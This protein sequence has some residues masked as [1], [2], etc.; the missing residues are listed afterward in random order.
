MINPD[1]LNAFLRMDGTATFTSGAV[2]L[3]LRGTALRASRSSRHVGGIPT[4]V[5]SE[6]E[7]EDAS[8]ADAFH[9]LAKHL[10]YPDTPAGE[11]SY[12]VVRR[13][14]GTVEIV[15]VPADSEQP[16]TVIRVASETP[17]STYPGWARAETFTSLEDAFEAFTKRTER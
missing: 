7:S 9:R 5:C 16:S 17:I 3:A 11:P 15:C 1:T 10:M 12:H 2:T 4:W 8:M 14:P 13:A 6:L